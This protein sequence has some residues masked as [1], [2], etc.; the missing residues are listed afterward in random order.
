M[1]VQRRRRGKIPITRQL[2][3]NREQKLRYNQQVRRSGL[4]VAKYLRDVRGI[5]QALIDL[6]LKPLRNTLRVIPLR[7]LRLTLPD[8]QMF[9]LN[10]L[11]TLSPYRS[12]SRLYDTIGDRT[13]SN[14]PSRID[15]PWP[16]T[17]ELMWN[18]M[19][20]GRRF[21]FAPTGDE[22]EYPLMRL[23][24]GPMGYGTYSTGERRLLGYGS[25]Q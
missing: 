13:T 2:A 19:M 7:D 16:T 21:T 1:R 6:I 23:V 25:F 8:L 14:L 3:M 5:P 4:L 10:P 22:T 20:G 24:R 9:A 18:E 17:A 11:D 15:W 12:Y